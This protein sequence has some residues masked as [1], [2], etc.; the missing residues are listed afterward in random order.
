[1]SYE[2]SGS[3]AS[4]TSTN[5][6]GTSVVSTWTLTLG[7]GL[8]QTDQI[9]LTNGDIAATSVTDSKATQTLALSEAGA[10]GAAAYAHAPEARHG[11]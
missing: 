8:T 10:A 6:D 2:F 3:T 5:P 4:Q 11:T 1:M 7:S 9:R